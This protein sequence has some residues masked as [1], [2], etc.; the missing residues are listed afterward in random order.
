MP[1]AGG[2]FYGKCENLSTGSV[3]MVVQLHRLPLWYM[4]LY[5]FIDFSLIC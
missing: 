4:S 1:F 3:V 2:F 5:I